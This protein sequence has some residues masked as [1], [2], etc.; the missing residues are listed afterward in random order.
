MWASGWVTFCCRASK[1]FP[2]LDLNFQVPSEEEVEESLFEG[3][4]DPR[5]FSDAPRSTD[6]LRE[7]E[8]PAEA[9]SPSLLV[10]ASP[11]I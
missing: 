2:S 7:A 3:E 4:A 1:A 8:N 11:S 9:S 10:E 6:C 5:M